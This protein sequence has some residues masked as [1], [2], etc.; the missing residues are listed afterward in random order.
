MFLKFT[1]L[2]KRMFNRFKPHAY[3]PPKGVLIVPLSNLSLL[4]LSRDLT[5]GCLLL[6]LTL[7]NLL[8]FQ[9]RRLGH[10]HHAYTFPAPTSHFSSF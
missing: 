5:A 2:K 8:L 3:L 6:L 4:V 9:A 10:T 7:G 1:H